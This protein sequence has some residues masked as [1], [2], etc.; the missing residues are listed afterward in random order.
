MTVHLYFYDDELNVIHKGEFDMARLDELFA[1]RLANSKMSFEYIEERISKTNF[2]LS[3]SK[4][5]F[6]DVGISDENT[7]V[8]YSKGVY[9]SKG[10][11]GSFQKMFSSKDFFDFIEVDWATARMVCQDY[12][13]M[14]R[15]AFEQKYHHYFDE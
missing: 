14:D 2:I 12:V 6:L 3:C 5:D 1:N 7:I 11:F 13:V 4:T 15:Q 10:L 9:H 8:L